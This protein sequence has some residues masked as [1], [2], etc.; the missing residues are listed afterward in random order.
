MG[1]LG[2]RPRGS[3]GSVGAIL[4][5]ALVFC[6]AGRGGQTVYPVVRSQLGLDMNGPQLWPFVGGQDL[7]ERAQ[8]ASQIGADEMVRIRE[9][10]FIHRLP[11]E[12]STTIRCFFS[13]IHNSKIIAM[14]E[15]LFA[16]RSGN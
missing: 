10:W 7:G 3:V 8:S 14:V 4:P 13:R 1:P 15:I 6:W 9:I 2:Q 12:L 5:V 11:P 16:D